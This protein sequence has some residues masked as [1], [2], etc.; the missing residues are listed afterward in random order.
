MVGEFSSHVSTLH[1]GVWGMLS[2]VL[3]VGWG[4]GVSGS[5]VVLL[6]GV[7]LCASGMMGG[8]LVVRIRRLRLKLLSQQVVEEPQARLIRSLPRRR[9]VRLLSRKEREAA[10]HRPLVAAVIVRLRMIVRRVLSFVV[11]SVR[12]TLSFVLV[13]M[14][15]CV[16]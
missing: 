9:A 15:R 3:A 5:D 2:G 12:I 14:R 6:W 13:R 7:H 4:C 16:R 10:R 11:V 8:C 1:R